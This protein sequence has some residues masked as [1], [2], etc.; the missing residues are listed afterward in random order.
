MNALDIEK[1][2]SKALEMARVAY[3]HEEVPVGTVIVKE[4]KIIGRGF[5]QVIKKNIVTSHAELNA[6]ADASQ[7]IDNYRLVDCDMFVT[8][9]PC[10]MCAKA[11]VDARIKSLYFGAHEPKTGAI[12]SI[13]HFLSR[14]HLNHQ[15][16]FSGGHLQVESSDLL[17]K[18]FQ[19]RRKK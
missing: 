1:F 8:L 3:E 6:I 4:G 5:N 15:V 14:D 16:Y 10:H 19:S 11:I 17:R 18:F 13:D 7:N 2:M 9:E 12:E